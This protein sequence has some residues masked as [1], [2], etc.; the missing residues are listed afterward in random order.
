MHHIA[1]QRR[2][3]AIFRKQRDLSGLPVA[4][5]KCLDCLAPCRSL[6]IVDLSQMQ[7]VPLY[8]APAGHTAVFNDAPIAVL[9]AVLAANLVAQKHDARLPKPPAVSQGTWSAPHAVS[10]VFPVLLLRF[11]VTYRSRRKAK[12]PEL[13]VSVESRRGA[14]S[15]RAIRFPSPLVKLDGPISGIQLSDW[16]HLATVGGA[17]R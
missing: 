3:R 10:A 17:P 11:S 5:V 4:L 16:L 6:I 8:R 1:I 13:P 14:V 9:L 7:H 2:P 15:L 12:F